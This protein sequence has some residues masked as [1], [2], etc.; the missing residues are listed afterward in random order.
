MASYE[1]KILDCFDDD[2]FI[3][4]KYNNETGFGQFISIRGEYLSSPFHLMFDKSTA[5]K[6]AKALRTE[7]N[8]IQEV[9]NV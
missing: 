9:D 7:I 5:I 2:N 4:V 1:L 6:L 3:N 8:K